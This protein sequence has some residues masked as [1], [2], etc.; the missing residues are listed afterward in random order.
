MPKTLNVPA[1]DGLISKRT[2]ETPEAGGTAPS[3]AV[4][5]TL[6]VPETTAAV[7]GEVTLPLGAALSTVFGRPGRSSF[8][9]LPVVSVTTA[10]RS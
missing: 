8:A 5:A 2:A 7:A 4:A 10:R 6:T 9:T 3:V 1:P